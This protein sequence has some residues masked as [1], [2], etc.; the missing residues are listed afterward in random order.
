MISKDYKAIID[1]IDDIIGVNT[2]EGNNIKRAIKNYFD[3]RPVSVK[4]VSQDNKSFN[5]TDIS[6]HSE[7]ADKAMKRYTQRLK[8]ETD[9]LKKKGEFC[10]ISGWDT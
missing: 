9:E 7:E 5:I 4:L 10:G 6:R 8:I 3:T 2:K 1:I